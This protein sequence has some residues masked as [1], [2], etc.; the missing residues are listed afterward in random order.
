MGDVQGGL[1][2]MLKGKKG[3]G[4]R[5]GNRRGEYESRGYICMEM[6]Y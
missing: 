1:L 6:L 2:W 4:M 3:W 5:K